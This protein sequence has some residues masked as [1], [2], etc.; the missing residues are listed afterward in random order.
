MDITEHPEGRYLL[1]REGEHCCSCPLDLLTGRLVA[2]ELGTVHSGKP[3][4]CKRLIALRN[5]LLNLAPIVAQRCMHKVHVRREAVVSV[6]LLSQRT[7]ERKILMEEFGNLG[8]IVLIPEFLVKRLND[9]SMVA[10]IRQIKHLIRIR[11]P[12]AFRPHTTGH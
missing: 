3:Q 4:A 1:T 7:T 11:G 6:L 12:Y 5:H 2:K 9:G 8:C 10:H